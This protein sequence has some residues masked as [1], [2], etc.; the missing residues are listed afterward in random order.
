MV[1]GAWLSLLLQSGFV[2]QPV[3]QPSTPWLAKRKRR[4]KRVRKKAKRVAPKAVAKPA[5]KSKAPSA[6]VPSTPAKPKPNLGAVPGD[7]RPGIAA[8]D[9]VAVKGVDEASA[10]I[11]NEVILSRLK[12]SGRF[13]A[14]IGSS[15]IVAMLSME[16]QKQALGCDDDSCL[17][18]LGGALGV[19]Y[20]F[21]ADVGALGGRLVLNLKILQ[22]DEA[23]VAER[24][25]RMFADEAALLDGVNQTIDELVQGAFGEAKEEAPAAVSQSKSDAPATSKS[26]VSDGRAKAGPNWF[27][28]GLGLVGLGVAG[29]SYGVHAEEERRAFDASQTVVDHDVLQER[30]DEANNLLG[31]GYGLMAGAVIWSLL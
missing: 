15:D 29:Y 19:P 9:L 30:V 6:P 4:G 26:V 22:V 8:L 1:T 17:A 20:L 10:R 2:T 13:S 11:L 7:K 21:S 23:R 16:Q 24:I 25:T 18:Q 3:V 5:A 27:A 14:I 31:L 12:A 28:L